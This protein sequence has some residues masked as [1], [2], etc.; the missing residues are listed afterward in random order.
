MAGDPFY[1]SRIWRQCRGSYLKHNPICSIPGCGERAVQ[2][3]HVI[4][5]RRGGAEFD[6]SNLIGMCKP[7]HSEKTARF[8]G[9]FGNKIQTDQTLCDV[10]GLP[11]ATDHHWNRK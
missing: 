8:D 4:S 9:G 5:R 1:Y 11:T 7:H 10:N 2:V 3:D 6:W